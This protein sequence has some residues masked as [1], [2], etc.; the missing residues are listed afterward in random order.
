[1]PSKTLIRAAETLHHAS[2]AQRFSGISAS[3]RI[4]DWGAVARQKD[5][6]VARLRQA[7]YLDLLPAYNYV[8]YLEGKACLQEGGVLVGGEPIAATKI[9]IATGARPAVPDIP[10]IAGVGY[11]T[12]TT[13]L[14]LTALPRS[15]S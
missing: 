10:G 1:V 3:A 5:D 6:L 13:A 9:I 4:D 2:T 14:E 7:K 12:S 11:L 8:A 15:Y